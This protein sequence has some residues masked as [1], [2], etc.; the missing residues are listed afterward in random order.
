MDAAG[1]GGCIKRLT[2]FLDPRGVEVH[3]VG[4]PN[5]QEQGH[6]WL[7]RFWV[8][9]PSRGRIAIFDRSWYGRVLVEP[10]EGFCTR[11]EYERAFHQIRE[12]EQQLTIEGTA[13]AKFWLHVDTDEQL[14]R[15]QAREN[16]PLKAW[17]ITAE[18]W[19]NRKR[20]EDYVKYA[21]AM[22]ASTN[23]PH[24]PWFL[25]PGNDKNYARIEVLERVA[26]VLRRAANTTLTAA[27][28]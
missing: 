10:I 4:A 19:R 27:A 15:F 1:K 26:D 9:L 22:F 2:Q 7:R 13:L 17:K 24:A 21:D 16:D 14:K 18:D 28:G 25:V 5:S 6:H 20:F 11:E 23:A 8:R 12:F 3:A